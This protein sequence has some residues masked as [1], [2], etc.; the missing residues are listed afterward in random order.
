MSY[1]E[2]NILGFYNRSSVLIVAEISANHG[3]KF[4]RAVSLIKQAKKCG[5]D[6]VK[7]QTYTPDTLTI[8]VNNKYFRIKHSQWGGQT[9]YQ[10]YEKAFTPWSWFKRLKK[11][12]DDLGVIFFSSVFDKTSVDF[13]EE[14]NVPYHKISSFELVDIPLIEYAAK[15]KKPLML[16]TG[17]SIPQEI[18]NAFNAAKRSGCKEVALLKCVSNYPAKPEEMNLKAI[19][20]LQKKFNCCIGL[21]DH[22]LG[23]GVAIAAVSLGAKIIEKHFTLSRNFR[24]PDNFFSLEPQEFKSLVSNIRIIEKAIGKANYK[25]TNNEKEMRNFRRSLFV[26]KDIKKGDVYS[27]KNISSIRP[28][29]G[30]PPKE[31]KHI[32]GRNAKVNIKRGT[33]LKKN[34]ID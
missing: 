10:L 9:L 28:A 21:S 17:M 16:S 24:T 27:E 33:P 26:I 34:L 30:L 1:R 19:P 23:I 15:T 18:E 25:L 7:F 14:L 3:Q 6:A 22:S 8:D 2:K 20:N 11:I 5:A 13:L 32:I 4:N 29:Y 12:A 31:F